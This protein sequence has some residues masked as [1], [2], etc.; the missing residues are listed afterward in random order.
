[1]QF[2]TTRRRH[3]KG[4]LGLVAMIGLVACHGGDGPPSN[5][6]NALPGSSAAH[7]SGAAAAVAVA[8]SLPVELR[9]GVR[10]VPLQ[11]H[12]FAVTLQL[13]A[14]SPQPAL[15]LVLRG[16]DGLD[17]QGPSEMSVDRLD[18]GTPKSF[19]VTLNGTGQGLHLLSIDVMQDLSGGGSRSFQFPV[20][21]TPR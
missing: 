17:I 7:G 3:V 11:N 10:D 18:P 13:T 8:G 2:R 21:V 12:V 14:S 19:D 1:M 4:F 20:L 9:V 6:A 5:G 15:R 16:E